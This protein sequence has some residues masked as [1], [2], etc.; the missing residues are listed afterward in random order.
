MFLGDSVSI[1]RIALLIV[2]RI[3]AASP[4]DAYTVG[5][6]MRL[7]TVVWSYAMGVKAKSSYSTARIFFRRE[8]LFRKNGYQL[9]GLVNIR[10]H[11]WFWGVGVGQMEEALCGTFFIMYALKTGMLGWARKVMM[12]TSLSV[13]C[14][15]IHWAGVEVT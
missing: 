6:F 13:L 4:E 3:C 8:S 2:A 10:L 15:A 7:Q 1:F 11:M 9:V 12:A 5:R 14:C